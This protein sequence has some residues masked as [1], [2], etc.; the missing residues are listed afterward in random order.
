MDIVIRTGALIDGTGGVP[1]ADGALWV[2][3]GCIVAAGPFAGLGVPADAQ[4]LD[5]RPHHVLPGLI[6]CHVHL[7][8]TPEP[9]GLGRTRQVGDERLLLRCVANARAA[10]ATGLTT[11]RDCG[12]QDTGVLA[13]ARAIAD[14]LLVGPRIVAAGAPITTTGGHCWWL[15]LEAEGVEGVRVA[16]R[17]LHKQG[18][19][20]VK[21]MVTGGGLTPGSNSRAAQYSQEE[22]AAIVEDAHRLGKRVTG[23]IHGTEGIHRALAA[24]FEGIEHGSWLARAGEGRDYVPE[25][26]D[27]VVRRG[28]FVCR[29]IAGFERVPLEEATPAHRFYADYA[30]MRNMVQDGVRLIAGTDS[31]IDHTPF[32]G[33]STT[34]ETMAGLAGMPVAAVLDSATRLAAEGIGLAGEI[35][36]LTPGKRADLI[37]VDGNPLA[38]LRVLRHVRVVVRDGVVVARDGVVMGV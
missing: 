11:V 16:V 37:A 7:V 1:I 5:L 32:T 6:D 21:V 4:L 24:G 18:A 27:E 28:I 3:G 12:C 36:T 17:R 31:G 35:G 38:D 23:H 15:G 14:G 10:L 13:L 34:L 8:G 30:V 33:F 9:G 29:S 2:R 22:L 20:F 19:D 25:L 26:A